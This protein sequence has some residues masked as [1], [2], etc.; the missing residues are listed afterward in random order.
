MCREFNVALF[1][2]RFTG[3]RILISGPF[4]VRFD[5]PTI[6]FFKKE[7]DKEGR[8]KLCSLWLYPME[9]FEV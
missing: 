2:H 5:A 8:E 7:K 3:E 6:E 9:P 4:S 1:S